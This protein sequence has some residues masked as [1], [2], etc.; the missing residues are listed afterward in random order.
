MIIVYFYAKF[1]SKCGIIRNISEY[2][3]R[4]VNRPYGSLNII[5]RTN[6]DLSVMFFDFY[7]FVMFYSDD[8]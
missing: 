6:H 2:F 7:Y 5:V 4:F 3:G 1:M 8:S